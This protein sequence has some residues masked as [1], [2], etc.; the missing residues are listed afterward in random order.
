MSANPQTRPGDLIRNIPEFSAEQTVRNA[1]NNTSVP[2]TDRLLR[3]IDSQT[4]QRLRKIRQLSLGDRV[5]PSATHTRFSHA[6]GVYLNILDYLRRLDQFPEFHSQFEEKD[7]LAVLLAGLLHDLGHYPY[8]HQLDHLPGFPAH[9]DFTIALIE[10]R[11][12]YKGENL[13]EM[14]HEWF[15]VEAER[16]TQLLGPAAKL[17]DKYRLLKQLIDSPID[18]DKCDYLPR[19]SYFC[20]L[21]YGAGFDRGRFIASLTPSKDGKSLCIHEKGLISA[22]RFQ[23]SRYWMYRSV[24]WG[25]TVR[26]LITMLSKAC[27]YLKGLDK[28]ALWPHILMDFNDHNFLDWLAERLDEPGR[29]LIEMV[30]NRREPYKRLF[31]ISYHHDSNTFSQLQDERLRRD[32][33]QWA[34]DWFKKR[35]GDPREHHLIW[36]VPP[37]YKTDTWETFPIKLKSGGE[38]PIHKESPVIE[39]LSNA[40]LFGVRKIRLFCHP[41]LAEIAERHADEMPRIQDLI[42]KPLFPES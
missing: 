19:D 13:R 17:P 24:Y 34:V 37:R 36:D 18:A 38:S 26:A 21:D 9:E 10:G 32:L 6:L 33:T 40:F 16:I 2:V 1:P 8:S 22:E 5:F 42:Q 39:A 14:I 27:D 11:M 29:E 20:G 4:F 7:Y 23:L 31:T 25:H 35:G 3:I 12:T 30:H 15:G 28:E 41:E